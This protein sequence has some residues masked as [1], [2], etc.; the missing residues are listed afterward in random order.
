MY[1]NIYYVSLALTPFKSASARI[2]AV[3]RHMV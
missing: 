2:L 3:K 1:K